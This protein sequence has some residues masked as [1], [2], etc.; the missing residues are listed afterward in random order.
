LSGQIALQPL[1]DWAIL[2]L[3]EAGNVGDSYEWAD[4][5][6]AEAYDWYMSQRL[7]KARASRLLRALT[8]SLGVLG[9]LFP[10][11]ALASRLQVNSDWGF[12]LLAM[13]GGCILADRSF[14]FSSSWMRY[15]TAALAL[16]SALVSTRN[17]LLVVLSDM[18]PD[19]LEDYT[20]RIA[21]L[22]SQLVDTVQQV[23]SEEAEQWTRQFHAS[24]NELERRVSSQ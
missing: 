12:L 4:H 15:M 6:C 10:F 21:L 16:Q 14:G 22:S 9:T 3:H 2:R 5:Q 20:S 7:P 18:K 1:P 17:R 11:V 19:S 8:I 24:L 13:A 23:V